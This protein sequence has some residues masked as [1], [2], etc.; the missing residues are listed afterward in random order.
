MTE[1]ENK[2]IIMARM[3]LALAKHGVHTSLDM[4]VSNPSFTCLTYALDG[5]FK[6]VYPT[7]YTEEQLLDVWSKIES[8]GVDALSELGV[9][10]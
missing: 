7:D 4:Y 10:K 1:A 8:E 9:S 6:M 3:Q 2:H 5:E